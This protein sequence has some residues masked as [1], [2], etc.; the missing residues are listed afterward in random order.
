[1]EVVR[2]CMAYVCVMSFPNYTKNG[3]SVGQ[4]IDYFGCSG[5]LSEFRL[6]PGGIALICKQWLGSYWQAIATN[7]VLPST[8]QMER[9]WYELSLATYLVIGMCIGIT[10]RGRVTTG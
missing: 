10:L 7:A 6:F 8:E 1:M 3:L 5:Q 2:Q 4:K 9:A